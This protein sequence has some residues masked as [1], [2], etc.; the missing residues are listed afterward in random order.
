MNQ[1]PSPLERGAVFLC[2]AGAAALLSLPLANPDL[3]W[4][5]SAGRWA[6]EHGA[7]PAA[8]WLSHTKA[9]VPWADFEWLAQLAY[10]GAL[11]SGGMA[12]LWALKA[13]VL[14]AAGAVL[15]RLLGRLGA[16]PAG[17]ALGV[18]AWLLA[19]PSAN[20]LRPENVSLLF[21]LLLLERL[22]AAR[23]E[24][25]D[26]AGRGELAAAAALFALWS[27]LHAGFVYGVGLLAL[28]G[29][30]AAAR[31]R[32]PR[33]LA[34]A[35]L[36]A[37]A[38]LANPY[39]VSVWTVPWQHWAALAELERYIFEWQEATV[40]SPWLAP[41]WA[42]MALSFAALA[43]RRWRAGS[44][45]P[46]HAG[47]LTALAWS[48]A[49]HVRTA[50]YFVAA[51]VPLTVSGLALGLGPRARRGL[52]YAGVLAALAFLAVLYRPVFARGTL[53][54][55]PLYVPARAARF[56][57]SER[58]ALKG[59]RLFNPWHWGGYLGWRLDGD[60]PVFADGRYLFHDLLAPM[61]EATKSPEAYAALL[62]GYGVDV[63]V[64]QRL[65]QFAPVVLELEGGGRET[66]LRPFYLFFYPRDTWALVHFD[67]RALVF[68]RRAAFDGAWVKAREYRWFRPDD[69]RAAQL[70]VLEGR[71]SFSAVAAEANRWGE[72]AELAERAAQRL[73]LADLARSS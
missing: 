22:E 54:F 40:L 37:A 43:L 67:D 66:V 73:W 18:F 50:P 72:G 70:D 58:P 20:D 30:C 51:A 49:A 64:V 27:N 46:E 69:L 68:V 61:Y 11:R 48:A 33:A 41:L 8:D 1:P 42:L 14:G 5:L 34:P 10:Y 63:A 44:A 21:F 32:S 23:L 38:V 25:R 17:R 9:G 13:A 35:A 55:D 12:G 57:E 45:P 52:A 4:H 62:D 60:V 36:A 71:A 39:G 15:W 53:G 24:G 28:Y 47:L 7:P 16:G 19:S 29:A 3:F 56:L 2:L 31:S 59:R 65:Q 6:A 26:A